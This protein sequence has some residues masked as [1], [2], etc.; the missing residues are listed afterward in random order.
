MPLAR[1]DG[2]RLMY[3]ARE[4]WQMIKLNNQKLEKQIKE[5]LQNSRFASV[6]EYLIYAACRDWGLARKRKL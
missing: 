5:I 6:E 2:S 1:V 4:Y 3:Q